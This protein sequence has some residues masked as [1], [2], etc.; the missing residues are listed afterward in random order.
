MRFTPSRSVLEKTLTPSS[1]TSWQPFM[2][3]AKCPPRRNVTP[4]SVTLAHRGRDRIL[5]PLPFGTAFAVSKPSPSIV[6]LPV[7]VRFVMPS[8]HIR[9]LWKWLCPKSWN[10]EKAFGSGASN[11]LDAARIVAP[12]FSCSVMLLFRW[13]VRDL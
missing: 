3:T 2:S 12:L 7:I 11:P 10:R 9:A 4:C 8:P 13:M 1:T 5:S 6:P